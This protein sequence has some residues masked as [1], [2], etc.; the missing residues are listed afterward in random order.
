MIFC[1]TLSLLL[2]LAFQQVNHTA[3]Q[4]TIVHVKTTP[5][6]KTVPSKHSFTNTFMGLGY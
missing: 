3:I 1:T 5:E 6:I 2:I 4:P